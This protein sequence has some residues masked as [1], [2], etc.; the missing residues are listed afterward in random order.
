[1][2]VRRTALVPAAAAALG[3]LVLAGTSGTA[4]PAKVAFGT[5]V[6]LTQPS[7]GGYEPSIKVDRFNNVFITAHKANH[8][9]F[10]GPSPT[11]PTPVR[12]ASYLWV[13]SDGG[14]TFKGLPG[15]TPLNENQAYPAAEGDFA[16]DNADHLFFIDTYLGDNS[17]TRW[18]LGG[19]NEIK[20]D[21]HR[22]VQGTGSLDDRPWLAAH[23]DGVVMYLGN[24]GTS[25]GGTPV[26]G[27]Y[28]V[29]MS[30]DGGTTFNPTGVNLPGSGWCHGAADPRKGSKRLYVVCGDDRESIYAYTSADDGRTFTRSTVATEI[31]GHTGATDTY[32]SVV[33]APDGTVHAL[34]N[35]PADEDQDGT[36]LV[37]FSSKD[38]A[39]WTRR[40]VTPR[41]GFHHYTWLDVARDGSLG[42][43]YYY[44]AERGKP[45]ML[46]GGVGTPGARPTTVPIA[47]VAGP[48]SSAPHGDF[49]QVAFGPDRKLNIAYTVSGGSVGVLGNPDV[50][51]V[52]QR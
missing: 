11:G 31:V 30:Y 4:A 16:L 29:Y 50:Y 39:R 33:V 51:Y 28:T 18:T 36:R 15:L 25:I 14:K 8:V 44:R 19:N 13:T 32:P 17:L 2:L 6:R 46:Y 41:T 3:A 34:A 48:N 22:P 24:A 20:A 49:F 37:L 40:D 7:F 21:F 52:K 26:S 43:G 23:G 10:A 38:G 42:Y 35:L 1:V 5:P 27:R 47:Q 9:I 12:G 45:W